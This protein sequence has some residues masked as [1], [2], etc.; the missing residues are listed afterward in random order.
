LKATGFK[1][2]AN[3]VAARPMARPGI[4]SDLQILREH[5]DRLK[6]GRSR[7]GRIPGYTATFIKRE[8]IGDALSDEEEIELKCRHEPFSV[9]MK[10]ITGEVGKEALYVAGRNDEQVLVRLGGLQGRLLPAF[11]LDP[12]GSVAMSESR[13]PIFK[14]GIL[15][16]N[17]LL[18]E[19]SE[20]DLQD[21]AYAHSH[22]D[23]TAASDGRPCNLYHFE[24]KKPQESPIYRKSVQYVDRQWNV[25]IQVLNY[26]WPAAGS[27]VQGAALDEA[28]L[29]EHYRYSEINAAAPLTEADF[30]RTNSEYRFRR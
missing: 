14:V 20:K 24:F 3:V 10:W 5:V 27:D 17:D 15:A 13:Y 16:L 9:Y 22:C 21:G 4:E 7:F 29:I 12:A 8:R 30:D 18:L 28:T 25:P 11:N 19:R 26:T 1:A 6:E 23:A 2:T